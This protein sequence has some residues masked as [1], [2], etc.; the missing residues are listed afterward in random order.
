MPFF[1]EWA[2]IITEKRLDKCITI[3]FPRNGLLDFNDICPETGSFCLM[4]S[5]YPKLYVLQHP[6]EFL[7]I[8]NIYALQVLV[9]GYN[10]PLSHHLAE[11]YILSSFN[12]HS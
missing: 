10:F 11:R 12:L 1:L 5:F 8:C 2:K 6:K 4:P 3:W 9:E 7:F